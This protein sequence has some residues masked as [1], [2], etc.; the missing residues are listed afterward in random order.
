MKKIKSLIC[1]VL[2]YITVFTTMTIAVSAKTVVDLP[3]TENVR[4][5]MYPDGVSVI[6]EPS[7]TNLKYEHIVYRSNTGKAGT[8]KKLATVERYNFYYMD[9]T[10]V[11]GNKYYYTVKSYLKEEGT[12][13][14]HVSEMSGK[15]KVTRTPAR[16]ELISTTNCGKGVLVKWSTLPTYYD[17]YIIY[18]STENKAGTWTKIAIIKNGKTGTYTDNKVSVGETYYYCIKYYKTVNGKN[19]CGKASPSKKST[20]KDVAVPQNLRTSYE[21]WDDGKIVIT[22]EKVPATIGYMVYR[23]ESGK[24]GT[25]KKIIVT[26]TNS[27]TEFIDD[28]AKPDTKYYYTVKSY[29]N[30]NGKNLYSGNAKVAS[31]GPDIICR[32]G[33]E[34]RIDSENRNAW[35]AFDLKGIREEDTKIFIDG[36]ELTYRDIDNFESFFED[37]PFTLRTWGENTTGDQICFDI[38]RKGTGEGTIRV[39]YEKDERIFAECKIICVE[40]ESDKYIF[41][42]GEKKDSVIAKVIEAEKLLKEGYDETTKDTNVADHKNIDKVRELVLSAEADIQE[43][44]MLLDKHRENVDEGLDYN[45][46]VLWVKSYESNLLVVKNKLEGEFTEEKTLE[47]TINYFGKMTN[48]YK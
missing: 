1:L 31:A 41:E 25:W 15:H 27:K 7:D 13:V 33:K 40:S 18:R 37:K 36:E 22:F 47:N 10:A 28:T 38:Y 5:E 19:I 46:L 16:G 12:G 32:K 17:G 21:Y 43:M 44:K 14:I 30:L 29:K 24:A 2:V 42:A 48:Y 6:W 8:W 11:M 39:Q 35:L 26:T 34:I 23:S 9:K 45:D 3:K 4:I 20:V